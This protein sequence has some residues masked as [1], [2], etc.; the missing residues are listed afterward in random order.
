MSPV[1]EHAEVE[2]NNINNYFNFMNLFKSFDSG[3]GKNMCNNTHSSGSVD[4][5]NPCRRRGWRLHHHGGGV[6]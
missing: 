5:S 6:C 2:S 1:R 4:S 3:I